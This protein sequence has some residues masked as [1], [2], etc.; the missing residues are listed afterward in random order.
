VNNVA[1]LGQ[2]ILANPA[3]ILQQVITNQLTNAGA[4]LAGLETLGAD[5]V[6][7]LQTIAAPALQDAVAAIAAGNFVAAAP[8]VVTALFQPLLFAA[9]PLLPVLQQVIEQP[10]A[11]LLAVTQQFQ[12]V[13][14]FAA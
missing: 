4:L 3:P 7:N 5:L 1:G 14:A 11:N 6:E 9:L 2:S 13:A 10:A 12:T 8:N